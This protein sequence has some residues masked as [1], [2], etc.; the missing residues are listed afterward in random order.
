MFIGLNWAVRSVRTACAVGTVSVTSGCQLLSG[1]VM[2]GKLFVT[3]VYCSLLYVTFS[4][5]RWYEKILW[6][7][8]TNF[9]CW[10]AFSDRSFFEG[11]GNNIVIPGLVFWSIVVFRS[12]LQCVECCFPSLFL[13]CCQLV[14]FIFRL[15]NQLYL[16]QNM[17]IKALVRL[18]LIVLME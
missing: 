12:T 16:I 6:T 8:T 9:S 5:M 2:W 13:L 4:C 7:V 18:N 15:S 14:Y 1:W 17:L 3:W 11:H 10:P